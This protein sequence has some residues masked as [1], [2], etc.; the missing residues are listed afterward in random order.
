ME[1]L[2][3]HCSRET[4]A[5]I[6]LLLRYREDSI[7]LESAGVCYQHGRTRAI[8]I[9]LCRAPY[10]TFCGTSID[11]FHKWRHILLSLCIYVNQTYW[12]HFGLNILQN[13]AHGSEANKAYQH[14]NKRILNL[15]AIMKEV[16]RSLEAEHSNVTS[17]R[18]CWF[19]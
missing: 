19:F 7:A 18:P 13:F 5:K 1:M 8:K 17:R 10:P 11:H 4:M 2:S 6:S 12:P 9:L 16:Y 15:T 14:Q 3:F